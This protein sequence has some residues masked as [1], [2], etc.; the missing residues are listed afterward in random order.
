MAISRLLTL[1]YCIHVEIFLKKAEIISLE[2]NVTFNENIE[3]LSF[4]PKDALNELD[5]NKDWEL[6]NQVTID[7]RSS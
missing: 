1:T 3:E 2:I 5:I 6:Q 4:D 7:Q